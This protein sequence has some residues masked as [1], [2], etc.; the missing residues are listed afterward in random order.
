[1]TVRPAVLVV[2][3]VM[4]ALPTSMLAARWAGEGSRPVT[5]LP[6]SWQ[7]YSA[8]RPASYT[9]VDATGAERP[10]TVVGLPPVLRA[11]GSGGLVPDRLC[12]Q[13]PDVV[14]VR[15]TGGP[16]PGLHRC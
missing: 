11:V 12:A 2:A 9:G 3:L 14:V 1:M 10:L 5:E 13:H 4:A 6:A 15:R 8:A 16:D 7:M